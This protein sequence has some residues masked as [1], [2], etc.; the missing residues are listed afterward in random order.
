[1]T[2]SGRSSPFGR[3]SQGC[4]TSFVAEDALDDP[5]RYFRPPRRTPLCDG[6]R[7]LD[8]RGTAPRY[9]QHRKRNEVALSGF[10]TPATALRPVSAHAGRALRVMCNGPEP[11]HAVDGSP[12]MPDQR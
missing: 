1:E 6:I 12:L 9:A 5:L 11:Y 7:R 3:N 10:R 8:P 2:Q 4:L